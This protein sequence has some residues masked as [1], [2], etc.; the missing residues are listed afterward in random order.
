[1]FSSA[2]NVAK[3]I[4]LG[5]TRYGTMSSNNKK[6]NPAEKA[7]LKQKAPQKRRH[8]SEDVVKEA[9]EDI[10]TLDDMIFPC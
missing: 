3:Q 10:K 4:Y 8:Y 5:Y 6:T 2:I 7:P 1:M 9:F